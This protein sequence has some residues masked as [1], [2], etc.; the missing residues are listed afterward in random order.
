MHQPR[1]RFYM[2]AGRTL[3]QEQHDETGKLKR[4]INLGFV[5]LNRKD[6]GFYEDLR[7]K[8]SL[9]LK[10]NKLLYRV[11]EYDAAGKASLVAIGW[12]TKFGSAMREDPLDL[13]Q[14]AFWI[15][16]R[17]GALES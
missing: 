10:G 6:G 16:R 7:G 5:G 1:D 11:W 17:H 14:L 4:A 13:A 8:V 15:A 9:K 3:R 12:D 2:A